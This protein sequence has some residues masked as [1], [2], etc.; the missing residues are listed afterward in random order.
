MQD[1]NLEENFHQAI[2]LF[3]QWTQNKKNPRD[4]Q[5]IYLQPGRDHIFQKPITQMSVNHLQQF[6]EMISTA[7]ALPAEDM[8]PPN[9]VLQLKWFYMPFHSEDGA[10]FV[11]SGQHLCNKMLESVV[12]YLKNIYK[13]QVANGSLVKKRKH[14]I[15]HCMKREMSQALR[16]QYNVMVTTACKARL[17][18][19]QLQVEGLQPR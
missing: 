8:Q 1:C 14:Q 13:L 11:E 2:Q 4:R 16:R 15:K 12:E 5:Y 19:S 17:L 6:K 3:I 7:E 9:K 18:S 10:K